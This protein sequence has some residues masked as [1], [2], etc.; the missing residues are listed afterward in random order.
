VELILK[1]VSTVR[2]EPRR[3]FEWAAMAREVAEGVGP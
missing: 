1:D 2:Y 3:L